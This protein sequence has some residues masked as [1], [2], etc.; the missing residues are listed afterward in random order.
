MAGKG[1]RLLRRFVAANLRA[2]RSEL[3]LTQEAV[4]L[5]AGFHRTFIG[6]IERAETNIS[7]DNLERLSQAL[8]IPAHDLLRPPVGRSE[9]EK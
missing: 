9:D 6:H 3:R 1:E 4:A 2:R 7:I 8:N 5:E